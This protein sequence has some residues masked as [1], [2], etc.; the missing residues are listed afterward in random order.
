MDGS[1]AGNQVRD[2]KEGRTLYIG[3]GTVVV[4]LAIILIVMMMRRRVV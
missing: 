3:I 1:P 2:P 4:I